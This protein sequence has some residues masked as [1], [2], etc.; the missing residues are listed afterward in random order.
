MPNQK[1]A[2]IISCILFIVAALVAAGTL[3][4]GPTEW[5]WAFEGFAAWVLSGAL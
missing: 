5:A 2:R 1:L 4:V 3:K